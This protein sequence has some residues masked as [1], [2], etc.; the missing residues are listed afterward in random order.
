M[1]EGSVSICVIGLNHKTAPVEIRERIAFGEDELPAALKELTALPGF[2]EGVILSTCNRVEVYFVCDSVP[3]GRELSFSFLSRGGHLEEGHIY[4]MHGRDAVVHLFSVASGLDSMVLGEPQIL[5]QVK[6]AYRKAVAAGTT[7][8]IL[9]KLFHWAFRAAK[10]VRR[11][12]RIGE[13]AVSVSYAAFELAKKVFDSFSDK[14]VLMVGAGEMVELALRHF[15]A[16]GIGKVYITN[17]TFKRAEELA[18]EFSGE[19][20][21]FEVF[22]DYLHVADIVLTCTG[23]M[24]P[25]MV[26]SDFEAAMK[27]RRGRYMFVIDIAVPRDVSP[28]V[29]QVDGVFLFDIDD[30]KDVVE[31]N[32]GE[33][34]KEAVRAKMI[35][36][37]EADK[38]MRWLSTLEVVPVI[39]KVKELFESIRKE[40]LSEALPKLKGELSQDKLAV[41]EKLTEAICNK[42]FHRVAIS[43]KNGDPSLKRAVSRMFLEGFDE[44]EAGNKEE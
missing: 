23:S 42:I 13:S 38:F 36:E 3:K 28:D 33:R 10:V 29:S 35:V 4:F 24:E 11:K 34:R 27:K 15:T 7:S 39:V 22:K 31:K 17:R 25:I 8:T 1:G 9:N 37:E 26:R 12:T 21:P 40:E 14:T 32:L 43:V 20:I 6:D 5:G 18:E 2:E 16:R 44:V 19:P 41:V 30:L